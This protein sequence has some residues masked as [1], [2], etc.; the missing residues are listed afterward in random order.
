MV[1]KPFQGFR[2]LIITIPGIGVLTADVIIAE[3][4]A[5]MTRFSTPATLHPG[6]ARRR[7][8][9]SPQ[10]A[11]S[12]PRRARATLPARSPRSSR[13]GMCTESDD[14]PRSPIPADSLSA[15][16]PESQRRD[17]A[18][19]ARCHLAHGHDRDPL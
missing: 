3:I 4:G 18:Q 14:L 19:N 5:D 12:P 17:P 13:H 7:A 2:E 1:I 10:D 16:S 15:R 8:A 11:S 6:P 9:T